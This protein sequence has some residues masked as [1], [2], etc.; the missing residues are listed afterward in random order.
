MALSGDI[1]VGD[2][3]LRP[4]ER[5]LLVRGAGV[6]LTS[7]EFDI[8]MMLAAH[9]GWVFSADQLSSDPEEGDRSRESVSVHVSRLRHKLAEAGAPDAIETVR[10]FG[11]R[12]R[13]A[14]PSE[15]DEGRA[16]A[17]RGMRDALWQLTE[18]VFEVEYSGN[19]AQQAAAQEVLESA[20]R[21]LFASLAD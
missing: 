20:R 8:V 14:L 13:G 18:A 5:A 11:Y 6:G 9:P 17:S 19:E 3:E 7:R 12:M 15:E 21:S 4:H 1:C 10:G 16:Q 2:L